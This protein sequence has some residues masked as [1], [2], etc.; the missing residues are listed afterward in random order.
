[1]CG[2][3]RT[4]PHRFEASNRICASICRV[5]L[6]CRS[7]FSV[8][9]HCPCSLKRD[10]TNDSRRP[11]S[12][13]PTASSLCRL[14]VKNTHRYILNARSSPVRDHHAYL[15]DQRLQYNP[16]I[17]IPPIFFPRLTT[18]PDIQSPGTD[19]SSDKAVS[20]ALLSTNELSAVFS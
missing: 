9:I 7:F 13:A 8:F 10:T 5:V 18:A 17:R 3:G 1:M 15:H 4:I 19:T 20:R 12:S 16:I 11:S 2:G 14:R 6:S